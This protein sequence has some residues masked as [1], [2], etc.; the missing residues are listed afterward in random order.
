MVRL[1][2]S[3]L[4]LS[5]QPYFFGCDESKFRLSSGRR[6]IVFDSIIPRTIARLPFLLNPFEDESSF[7]R[8][9]R[10]SSFTPFSF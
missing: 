2:G 7:R 10:I 1:R 8:D 9:A 4:T 6:R 3:D 5:G